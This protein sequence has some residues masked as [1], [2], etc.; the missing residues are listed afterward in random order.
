MQQWKWCSFEPCNHKTNRGRMLKIRCCAPVDERLKP[1]HHA[2]IITPQC[3]G[4]GMGKET[5]RKT[6]DSQ[7]NFTVMLGNSNKIND[8]EGKAGTQRLQREKPE[9]QTG[10][11]QKKLSS[12]TTA[13]PSDP[14]NLFPDWFNQFYRDQSAPALTFIYFQLSL[15]KMEGIDVGNHDDGSRCG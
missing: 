2:I 13:D 7:A 1:G 14:A 11:T 6:D 4:C 8:R 12:D 9:R 15:A 5:L 10:R 3:G